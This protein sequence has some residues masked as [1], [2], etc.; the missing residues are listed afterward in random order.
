MV[1]IAWQDAMAFAAWAGKRLPDEREWE[2][3]ARGG[4][5]GAIIVGKNQ[6]RMGAGWPIPGKAISL[7]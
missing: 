3:A 7:G 4:L 1:Q 5:D 2:F 6:Q